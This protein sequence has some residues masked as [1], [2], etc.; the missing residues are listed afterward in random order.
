MDSHPQ[1]TLLGWVEPILDE[2]HLD[3]SNTFTLS[4]HFYSFQ[5]WVAGK[6]ERMMEELAQRAEEEAAEIEMAERWGWVFYQR[7]HTYTLE[8][9]P[10]PSTGAGSGQ[11]SVAWAASSSFSYSSSRCD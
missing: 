4:L 1:F 5:I 3:V 9:S 10:S 7:V 2:F 6:R 11:G 8:L